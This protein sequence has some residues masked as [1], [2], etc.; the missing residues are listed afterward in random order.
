MF[1][2]FATCLNV[3]TECLNVVWVR[4]HVQ[5]WL[6]HLTGN[7]DI[8]L[9]L[10]KATAPSDKPHPFSSTLFTSPPPRALFHLA[11][12]WNLLTSTYK[13]R[14]SNFGNNKVTGR[15]SR[16]RVFSSNI[17]DEYAS[18]PYQGLNAFW[19]FCLGYILKNIRRRLT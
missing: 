3:V 1:I 6:L 16:V 15:R 11:M 9:T 2:N 17:V 18:H 14:S 10:F 8:K 19:P 7:W 5:R 13:G 12:I 4:L